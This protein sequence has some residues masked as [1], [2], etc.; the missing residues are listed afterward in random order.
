MEICGENF[1]QRKAWLFLEM[2]RDNHFLRFF[3]FELSDFEL[4]DFIKNS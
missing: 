3:I 1:M 2:C 4:S